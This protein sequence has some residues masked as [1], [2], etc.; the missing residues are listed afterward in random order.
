VVAAQLFCRFIDVLYF[1]IVDQTTAAPALKSRAVPWVLLLYYFQDNS[2]VSPD[3][4]G[5]RNLHGT[6]RD[7][8]VSG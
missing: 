4:R 7:A 5:S 2:S 1:V 6:A 3:V 8:E